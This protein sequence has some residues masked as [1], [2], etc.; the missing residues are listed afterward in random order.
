MHS[1]LK[2]HVEG[3]YNNKWA[4]QKKKKMVASCLAI[5]DMQY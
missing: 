2:I 3:R 1:T 5:K 4:K